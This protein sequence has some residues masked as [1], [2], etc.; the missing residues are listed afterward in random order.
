[1]HSNMAYIT[2][3]CYNFSPG[4]EIN[5]IQTDLK[6]FDLV[7]R[8]GASF[9]VRRLGRQRCPSTDGWKTTPLA[10]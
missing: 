4:G 7:I 10:G 2:R 5:T 3:F 9:S 8:L 6:T 1:M